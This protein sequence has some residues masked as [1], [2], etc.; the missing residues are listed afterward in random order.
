MQARL[1]YNHHLVPHLQ[2]KCCN[3]KVT[4]NQLM[5]G[6]KS[7]KQSVEFKK[8]PENDSKIMVHTYR[9]TRIS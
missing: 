8:Q 4:S 6:Y 5:A 7:K 1:Q 3:N 9:S 2:N